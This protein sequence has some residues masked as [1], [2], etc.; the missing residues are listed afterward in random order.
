M[1]QKTSLAMAKA[2]QKRGRPIT[3]AQVNLEAARGL[4][5]LVSR[6]PVAAQLVLTLIQHMKPGAGGVVV[7]SRNTMAEL[8]EVSLSSIERAL[9]VLIDE[10]W[11]Q[12]IRIG[13]APALAINHR[14]AWIGPRGDLPHAVFGATVI[15]SRS[16]QDDLA[17]NPPPMRSVPAMAQDEL[18]GMEDEKSV[19][20]ELDAVAQS[21]F[22]LGKAVRHGGRKTDAA[23]AFQ[24]L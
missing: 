5:G 14:V 2:P 10:G 1:T 24:S 20:D 7:V 13:G 8:L 3:W 17:L 6:Q 19:P 18:A 23:K 15:A 22:E 12:R 4:A 11:V 9:R 16:E 21:G